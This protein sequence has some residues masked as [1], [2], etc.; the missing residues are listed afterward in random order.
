V[1][2]SEVEVEAFNMGLKHLLA[3]YEDCYALLT[4][5]DIQ[6]GDFMADMNGIY[7][8]PEIDAFIGFLKVVACTKPKGDLP[9]IDEK[10]I[11]IPNHIKT[12][13]IWGAK[14]ELNDLGSPTV[15]NG[16]IN[17]IG[18]QIPQ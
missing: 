12:E 4:T 13:K 16:F 2:Y 3:K 15:R 10:Q 14:I 8:A 9:L 11:F 5:K 17:L 1:D 6:A 7:E 18:I